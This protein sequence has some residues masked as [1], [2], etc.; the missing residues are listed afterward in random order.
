MGTCDVDCGGVFYGTIMPIALVGTV[1]VGTMP[2]GT[3]LVGTV[4]C[5]LRAEPGRQTHS[6]V[7]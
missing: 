1:P 7:F 4:T 2:V 6:D 3:V 5:T